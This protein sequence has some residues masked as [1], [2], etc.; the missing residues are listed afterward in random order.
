MISKKK[1]LI[2]GGGG[3][4]GS[5]LSEYLLSFNNQVILFDISFPSELLKT[6][7][8]NLKVIIGNVFSKE[9][10]KKAS[11]G[12]DYIFHF[13]GIVGQ[14]NFSK[15]KIRAINTEL[16]GLKN[17]CSVS[18][19]N[20][21][22]K[23]IYNS[24]SGIYDLSERQN[25]NKDIINPYSYVKKFG[26]TYLNIFSKETKI[27]VLCLR[28]FN[29]Y[30]PKQNKSMVIQRFMNL[31]IQNKP[32]KIYS[33]G[34]QKRD[35]IYIDDYI[36]QTIYFAKNFKGTKIFDI[37][38]G[39]KI[40]IKKLANMI[41]AVANSKSEI[42]SVKVKNNFKYFYI[43]EIKNKLKIENKFKRPKAV[44]ELKQGLKLIKESLIEKKI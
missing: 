40:T 10:L 36:K 26:E 12:C 29:V 31:A 4:L 16:L 28:V 17:I 30:G 37:L 6:K 39:K 2:T 21:I 44:V 32:I 3:F 23:I 27:N 24:T 13:A 1:I 22:K 41:K 8:K 9:S 15:N 20:K 11:K 33:K 19:F 14:E 18:K 35:F 34:Y 38:S 25:K 43:H 7:N 42:K 5:H